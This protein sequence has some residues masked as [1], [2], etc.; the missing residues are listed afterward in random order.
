MLEEVK[1]LRELPILHGKVELPDYKGVCTGIYLINVI[2]L[3]KL[4][5]LNY[6]EG[7]IG[8]LIRLHTTGLTASNVICSAECLGHDKKG[9][10]QCRKKGV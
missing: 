3:S 1:F 8:W 6:E 10:L 2:K 7:L 4:F 5:I 9:I